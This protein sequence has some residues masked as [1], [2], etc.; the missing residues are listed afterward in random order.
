MNNADKMYLHEFV[1]G[2]SDDF[3]SWNFPHD[4]GNAYQMYPYDFVP[5]MLE[6]ICI[7]LC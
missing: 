3:F 1:R 5:D 4:M 7:C 6:D 2:L